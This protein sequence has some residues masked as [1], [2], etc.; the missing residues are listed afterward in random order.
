MSL[1]YKIELINTKENFYEICEWIK[2]QRDERVAEFETGRYTPETGEHAPFL[3]VG[4]CE[5]WED[6][7]FSD[8]LEVLNYAKTNQWKKFNEIGE[9]EVPLRE[10]I[11]ALKNEQAAII[12]Y[13]FH[14]CYK[15][16]VS[17]MDMIYIAPE[18][19]RKGLSL[20]L[21]EAM[22][23]QTKEFGYPFLEL[24]VEHSGMRNAL[25]KRGYKEAMFY[26]MRKDLRAGGLEEAIQKR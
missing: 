11:L 12:G 15:D 22:E 2:K 16:Y 1:D 21:L 3:R 8:Y 17:H 20:K 5:N 26:R 13:A 10:F 24:K 7:T 18:Y 23:K 9:E 14:I 25:A 4:E 19:R 6:L